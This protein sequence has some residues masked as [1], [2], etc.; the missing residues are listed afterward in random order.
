[1]SKQS[2]PKRGQTP[3][4]GQ[5]TRS[6]SGWSGRRRVFGPVSQWIVV[7]LLLVLAFAIIV[8]LTGAA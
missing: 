3:P 8:V 7:V 4:K 5:P 2:I 6:R 1:M